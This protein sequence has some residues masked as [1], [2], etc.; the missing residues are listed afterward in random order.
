MLGSFSMT[1]ELLVLFGTPL[2]SYG[3]MSILLTSLS[4]YSKCTDNQAK[5]NK[6]TN[7]PKTQKTNIKNTPKLR[8]T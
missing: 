6:T 1:A 2:C 3:F 7:K 5:S 4:S 8:R